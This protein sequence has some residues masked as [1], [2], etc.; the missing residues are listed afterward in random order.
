MEDFV[1]EFSPPTNK[2]T[3]LDCTLSVDGASK[4]NERR[5]RIVLEGLRD[6]LIGK[7]LKSEFKA[8]NNQSNY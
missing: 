1:A 8:R 6:L 5:T 2:K 7:A 4:V 3:P